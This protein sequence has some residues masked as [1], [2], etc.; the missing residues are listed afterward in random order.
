MEA[1]YGRIWRGE[2]IV[3]EKIEK[4]IEEFKDATQKNEYYS[5][6]GEWRKANVQAK[7]L[8]ENFAAI[9]EIGKDAREALLSLVDDKDLL[10]ALAAAVCSLKYNT[11]RS[12][13]T[14]EKIV[15]K[16]D[17]WTSYAAKLSIGNW[18]RGEWSLE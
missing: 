18:E 12:L 4:L 2:I 5:H 10:I 13:E 16:G 15:E 8:R 9:R 17:K 3:D 14:L 11:K 1:I 7:R 6:N